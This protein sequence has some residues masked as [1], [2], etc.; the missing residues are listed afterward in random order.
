MTEKNLPNPNFQ[1]IIEQYFCKIGL[2]LDNLSINKEGKEYGAC[3][4]SLNG[5]KVVHRVSKVTPIKI[6]QFVTVWKRDVNGK[7]TPYVIKDDFDIM[8]IA[9]EC[10]GRLGIFNF[11]KLVLAERGVITTDSKKGICGMRVY[12]P[13]DIVTNKQALKTQ[14]WQLKYF[15]EIE[16]QIIN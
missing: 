11:P 10:E 15:V 1:S 2:K 3:S 12:P 13:W 16:S 8:I 7:T 9:S 5:Q 4:Y 14:S 6:G